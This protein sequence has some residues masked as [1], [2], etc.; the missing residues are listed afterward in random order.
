MPKGTI[1]V[2]F[3]TFAKML[4]HGT[5]LPTFTVT[6]AWVGCDTVEV[7]IQSDQITEGFSMTAA[8][9]VDAQ[10]GP[11]HSPQDAASAQPVGD[12]P[13]MD[14]APSV[15]G[16]ET[17]SEQAA[18]SKPDVQAESPRKGRKHEK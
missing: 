13:I 8:F 2:P 16:G 3:D 4:Q 12:T 5:Y 17:S 1:H 11:R 18:T 9:V 7:F 6:G 14:R 15:S 10:A